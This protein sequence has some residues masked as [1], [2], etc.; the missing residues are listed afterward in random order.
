[1]LPP[2]EDLDRYA[3][4]LPDAGERLLAAS[5]RE[6]AHRHELEAHIARM[7]A[8]ELPRE[9]A[10]QQRTRLITFVLGLVYLGVTATAIAPGH[11]IIGTVG[12]ALGA[13]IVLW[14]SGTRPD[15]SYRDIR[16]D[17][18]ARTDDR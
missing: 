11:A 14:G 6:Q 5:E 13:V 10:R 18:R 1:M 15:G 9:H 7:R 16:L 4:H 17:G 3:N 12:A 8:Q 2:P